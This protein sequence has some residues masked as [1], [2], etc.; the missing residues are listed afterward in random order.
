M[1]VTADDI[2]KEIPANTKDFFDKRYYLHSAAH[3]MMF[4]ATF[5]TMTHE[6]LIE[7]IRSIHHAAQE[8]SDRLSII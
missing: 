8:A 6:E 4:A 1:N 7:T 5:M 2:L 3:N